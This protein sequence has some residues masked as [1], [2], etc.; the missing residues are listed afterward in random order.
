MTD[1]TR[2]V[3][4]LTEDLSL[5]WCTP[6]VI[7]D[8]CLPDIRYRTRKSQGRGRFSTIGQAEVAPSSVPPPHQQIS[9]GPSVGSSSDYRLGWDK[10][11]AEGVAEATD[12]FAIAPAQRVAWLLV[13]GWRVVVVEDLPPIRRFP[14]VNLAWIPSGKEWREL[15]LPSPVQGLPPYTLCG[16]LSLPSPQRLLH[17]PPPPPPPC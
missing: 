8:M 2:F 11:P 1:E 4:D 3:Y 12:C 15:R 17:W 7:A 5:V 14:C 10:L 16:T 6:W 9:A 13:W